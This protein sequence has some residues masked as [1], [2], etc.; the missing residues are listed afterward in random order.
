[1]YG[2]YLD[3]HVYIMYVYI[4]FICVVDVCVC[5]RVC[6]SVWRSVLDTKCM[7]HHIL[8]AKTVSLTKPGAYKLYI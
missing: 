2:V 4:Y 1:M 8:L 7:L 6:K 3:V 5:V